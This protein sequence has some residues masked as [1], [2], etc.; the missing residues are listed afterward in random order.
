MATKRLEDDRAFEA[1]L[2]CGICLERLTR[3][4][5]LTCGHSFCQSCMFKW[6]EGCSKI[7]CPVCKRLTSTLGSVESLPDDFRYHQFVDSIREVKVEEYQNV[8]IFVKNL[9]GKNIIITVELGED[10][11]D[12]KKK[13]ETREGIPPEV[14]RLIVGGKQLQDGNTLRK[15]KIKKDSHVHMVMRGT[16]GGINPWTTSSRLIGRQGCFAVCAQ[17]MR[18]GVT[19]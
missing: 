15:Y 18:D 11:L 12:L 9:K 16:G 2:S 19:L 8:Q 6:C 17:P 13:I 3:P 7:Y 5:L 10:V 1:V 4:K 14:Q